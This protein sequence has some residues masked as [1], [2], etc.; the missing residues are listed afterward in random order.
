MGE[1]E[2]DVIHVRGRAA[3]TEEVAGVRTPPFPGWPWGRL[4]LLALAG[5]LLAF[6]V[7]WLWDRRRGPVVWPE[8]PVATAIWL[9]T[10]P[11]FRDLMTGGTLARGDARA[12][13]DGLAGLVRRYVGGRYGIPALE[14][15]GPEMIAACRRLGYPLEPVRNL[16]GI[17]DEADRLRY[18][19]EPPTPAWCREKAVGFF[20]CVQATRVVPGPTPVPQ[21][22]VLEAEKAWTA[23]ARELDPTGRLMTTT[24]EG[25]H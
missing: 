4:A 22:R 9:D 2:S 11:G 10:A 21:E 19:P 15:T 14:M 24:R 25:G 17:V 20:G 12:F 23:V 1:W 16:A 7:V 13:L 18:D 8:R 5:G 6:L 3:G